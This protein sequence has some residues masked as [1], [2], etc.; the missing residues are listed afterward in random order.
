M[1]FLPV[2]QITAK[3]HQQ[4]AS[5]MAQKQAKNASPVSVKKV[6]M[7]A[8]PIFLAALA[9]VLF[10]C[11]TFDKGYTIWWNDNLYP[12]PHTA[13]DGFVDE[14]PDGFTEAGKLVYAENPQKTKENLSSNWTME[15][16][17]YVNYA[18]DST[19][20]FTAYNGYI[21]VKKK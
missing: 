19:V 8:V 15:G 20:Y 10:L 12:I 9:L 14:L 6:L 3:E 5:V 16:R 21:K 4:M 18:D 7:I 17:L 11:G 13:T 1:G 2:D